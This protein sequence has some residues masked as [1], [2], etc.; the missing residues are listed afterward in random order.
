MN[1]QI[2]V[3]IGSASEQ[4][5]NHLIARY[6]QSIAPSHLQFHVIDISK[7]ELYDR[8]LDAQEIPSYSAFRQAIAAVDAVLWIS[9]EHNG[10]YSAMLKNAIDI[11]SRPAGQSQW[12]GKPLGLIS[13]NAGGSTRAIDQLRIVASSSHISMPTAPYALAIGGIFSGAFN[14]SGELVAEIAQKSAQNFID[15]FAEFIARF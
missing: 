15:A 5:Y 9:P 4:S 12:L 2:G 14:D 10:S 6:L 7:L 11:G 13:V 8:D 3:L 1:K